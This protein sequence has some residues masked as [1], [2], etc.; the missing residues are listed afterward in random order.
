MLLL[1]KKW[2]NTLLEKIELLA[3]QPEL[4]RVVPE[5]NKNTIRELILG[6]YRII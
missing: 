3:I 2:A 6:N 5:I 1:L 4:G